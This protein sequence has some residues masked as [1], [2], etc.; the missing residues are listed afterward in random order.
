[1]SNDNH[2]PLISI[3]MK[4][5]K[6]QIFILL[7]FVIFSIQNALSQED[8]EKEIY[9]F[10][11]STIN[12]DSNKFNLK[13]RMVIYPF[14]EDTYS[15]F[16]DSI[17]K[18]EDID[19][20]KLQIEKNKFI[21][22]QSLINNS[23]VVSSKDLKKIFKSRKIF[24]R[25]GKQNGWNKFR[26]KYGNCLTTYSLPLFSIGL[27]YCIFYNWKQCDYD[28]GSGHVILYINNNGTWKF[29]KLLMGGIS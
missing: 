29:Y 22:K 26:E 13:D 11:A 24:N 28:V 19:T 17:F 21:W 8:S 3:K 15:Y 12:L 14:K 1:M 27:K 20:F 25:Y 5:K 4:M 23:N 10:I 6:S 9:R 18:Q 7:L 2:F 16:K